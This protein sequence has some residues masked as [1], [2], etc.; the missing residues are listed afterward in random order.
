MI[1]KVVIDTCTSGHQG[2]Y[3]SL[4]VMDTLPDHDERI[5]EKILLLMVP[6]FALA[7]LLRSFIDYH[8]DAKTSAFIPGVYAVISLASLLIFS[9]HKNFNVFRTTQLAVK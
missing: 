5:R 7:G 6:L 9:W 2:I 4:I 8:Y 1:A 3:C